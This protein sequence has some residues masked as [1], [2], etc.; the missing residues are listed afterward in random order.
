[1]PAGEL[2]DIVMRESVYAVEMSG[3]RAAQARENVKKVR[4]LVRRVENRG[5]TTIGRLARYFE[6]LRAGDESNAVI[7]AR[8]CVSLMTIHAAKGLEFPAVFV[9]NL[10]TPGRGGSPGVTVI[11]RSVDGEPEVAFRSTE[12]TKLEERR[13][14]EELRRLL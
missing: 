5:Y 2:I 8:G 7:E 10:H 12:G 13:E 4:A 14:V 9:V 1:M 6:T 3:L 11:D